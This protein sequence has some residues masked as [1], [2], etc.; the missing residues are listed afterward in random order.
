MNINW[1]LRLQNKVTLSAIVMGV[2]ALVYQS[3]GMFGIV[4]SISQDMV[5]NWAGMVINILVL[6]GV[7]TDPTT[8]GLNDSAQAMGYSS[9]KI[10]YQLASSKQRKRARHIWQVLFFLSFGIIYIPM[11]GAVIDPDVICT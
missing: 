10:D 8:N 5:V 9:P 1:K 7:V 11:N 3:L 6:I 2:I 4:P